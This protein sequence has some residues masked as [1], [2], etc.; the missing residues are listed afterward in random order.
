MM[1]KTSKNKNKMWRRMAE[2]INFDAGEK[3]QGRKFKNSM[4]TWP[5]QPTDLLAKLL[6]NAGVILQPI[7]TSE[8]LAEIEEDLL[9]SVES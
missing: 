1:A 4:Q 3:H 2:E 9:S 8:P 7:S 6:L 5:A